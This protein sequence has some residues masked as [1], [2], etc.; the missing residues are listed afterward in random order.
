MSSK[1]LAKDIEQNLD[2]IR[3][4]LEYL[5]LKVIMQ[6]IESSSREKITLNKSRVGGQRHWTGLQTFGLLA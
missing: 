5:I 1:G 4:R 2:K 3:C 6:N